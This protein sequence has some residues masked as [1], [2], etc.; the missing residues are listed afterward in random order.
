MTCLMVWVQRHRL[1]DRLGAAGQVA[2]GDDL[3]QRA[4]DVRLEAEVHGDVTARE[5]RNSLIMSDDVPTLHR[6][7]VE[8]AF[9]VPEA[10]RPMSGPV[11]PRFK[12]LV[13]CC[14]RVER[15]FQ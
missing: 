10:G 7:I 14:S 9:V 4:D 3:A 5:E 8:G 1:M 13:L 6:F 11:F 12:T 15:K 2:V